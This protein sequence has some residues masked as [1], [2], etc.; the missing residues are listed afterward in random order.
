MRLPILDRFRL[1]HD[2][3]DVVDGLSRDDE[4]IHAAIAAGR[5]EVAEQLVEAQ[6]R[7]A[8]HTLTAAETA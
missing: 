4:A 7:S 1:L 6:I 5:A 8:W 2:W 3:E